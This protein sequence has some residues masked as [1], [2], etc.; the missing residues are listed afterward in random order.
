MLAFSAPGQQYFAQNYGMKEGLPHSTVYRI[1]QD[2]KGFMWFCTDYGLSCFDGK[3]F[4]NFYAKDGLTSNSIMSISEDSKGNKLVSTVAGGISVISGPTISASAD[5]ARLP[6]DIIY[7]TRGKG[8]TWF[9]N[10]LHEQ[11]I[12]RSI[13]GRFDTITFGNKKTKLNK[14]TLQ[15]DTVF[16][17]CTDGIYY[18]NDSTIRLLYKNIS[19]EDIV[20]F[21]KAC[22]GDTWLAFKSKISLLHDNKIT[23]TFSIPHHTVNNI[24]ADK[25]GNV[26]ITTSDYRIMMI[27]NNALSDI[28]D[29]LSI[30]KTII[31]DLYA[32]SEGNIWMASYNH[33]VYRINSLDAINY[34]TRDNISIYTRWLSGFKK[35]E[36]LIA[37]MGQISVWKNGKIN[38][39]H[40]DLL[41]H[42]QYVYFAQPL[43]GKLYVGV[44]D[45]LIIK[46]LSFPYE[47]KLCPEN[48]MGV[49]AISI[50]KDSKGN[51]WLGGF[52][53][54]FRLQNGS[55]ITDD[56]SQ[57]IKD[58]RY[59]VIFEDHR[60][61][62]WLGT[63]SGL[64]WY[65]THNYEIVKL[66]G[67]NGAINNINAIFEDSHKRV[68]VGTEAGLVCFVDGKA[69][70]FTTENGLTSN[71]CNTITEDKNKR[72]WIGT[73]NGLS[74]VDLKTLQ[75]NA[76]L[77]NIYPREVL[78]LYC[79]DGDTI[80]A[81]TSDG[82]S[83]I[84]VNRLNDDTLTPRLYITSVR[85]FKRQV[86]NPESIRL[87]HDENR[88]VIDFIGISF[89]HADMV[90]YKYKITGLDDNWHYTKNNS[91]ELSALPPGTYSLV[92]NARQ[93]KGKWSESVVMPLIIATPF[94]Q[95]WWFMAAAA[96]SLVV[97]IVLVTKQQISRREYDKRKQLLI[98]NKINYLKQQALN[99]LINPHFIFN[100]MNS[101]QHYLNKH[102]NDLAN[103]Y[104]AD[105]AN[106]IR[107]TLEQS[108]EAFIK[109]EEEIARIK[110]YLSLEQLRFDDLLQYEIYTDP[111]LDPSAIYIPNMILQPYV[112]NA[113]W[114][115]IMPKN[116]TGNITLRFVKHTEQQIKISIR[117][118]GVGM[119]EAMESRGRTRRR[120]LGRMLT[121]ERLELLKNLSGQFYSVITSE[122]VPPG[123]IIEIFLPLVPD[124]EI[125]QQIEDEISR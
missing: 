107:M 97:T 106:L 4:Q 77:L 88:L 115:G 122:S 123:T 63:N 5:N 99:A 16:F 93:N 17:S 21:T 39:V 28:T 52:R 100:S 33:G 121:N 34:S 47:E 25:P 18:S 83:L 111:L 51:I 86:K 56:I 40:I 91:I 7:A 27:R 103:A 75:A 6:K 60:G 44:P 42:N 31:N 96:L 43:D 65:N 101:I 57:T 117:D 98:F 64:V 105:F 67:G 10:I 55:F 20:D 119:K 92:L 118:D 66:P 70:L 78:S 45:G 112:E 76:Y 35:D 49:G 74:Y 89:R 85:T 109:L 9:K 80:F 24:L 61:K 102:D 41:K 79:N 48:D 73:L 82:V 72:L 14:I 32:D 68:W 19:D 124:T 104:L 87:A 108:G 94:W 95:T 120:P 90:E 114:H 1:F 8:I 113:I 84:T 81:G 15:K 29:N 23:Q 59:K 62:L 36:V 13:D 110:L 22:N 71:K 26:W 46:N 116:S 38:P 11:L 50:C 54:L 2:N 125:L 30:P 58:K 69:Q 3:S 12:Y 37:T 53:S